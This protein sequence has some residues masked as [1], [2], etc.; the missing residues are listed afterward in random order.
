[1]MH[2]NINFFSSSNRL[3]CDS[4]KNV[5]SANNVV[6]NSDASGKSLICKIKSS[7]PKDKP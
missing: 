7:G 1:M 6:E 3:L 2:L 5:S 4:V